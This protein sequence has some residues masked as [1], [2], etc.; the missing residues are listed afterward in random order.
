MYKLANKSTVVLQLSALAARR[1]RSH[2]TVLP[3]PKTPETERKSVRAANAS[4]NPSLEIGATRNAAN[5]GPEGLEDLNARR[6]EIERT[7]K[8]QF[9]V[10]ARIRPEVGY[11]SPD[12]EDPAMAVRSRSD[13]RVSLGLV[14]NEMVDVDEL[15]ELGS[16]SEEKIQPRGNLSYSGERSV[17]RN[18]CEAARALTGDNIVRH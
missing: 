15:A 10:Q 13:E 4:K 12:L 9:N 6:R 18:F 5:S 8:D 16:G 2:E 11:G 1:L 3:T 7:L 14:D 17:A